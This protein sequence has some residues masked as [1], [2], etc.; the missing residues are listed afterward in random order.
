MNLDNRQAI[1]DN[2]HADPDTIRDA[3]TEAL[4]RIDGG[5]LGWTDTA[6]EQEVI[7]TAAMNPSTPADILE[8]LAQEMFT[9]WRV[10]ANEETEAGLLHRIVTDYSTFS[11]DDLRA[12]VCV[13]MH[14][15]TQPDTLVA[16][17]HYVIGNPRQG[18]AYLASHL[19]PTAQ[20]SERDGPIQT[21]VAVLGH[22]KTPDSL[23]EQIWRHL[24]SATRH[25]GG[26]T[27]FDPALVDD[28]GELL[29]GHYS[30]DESEAERIQRWLLLGEPTPK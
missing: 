18:D 21:L 13:A 22:Y 16:V 26:I 20:F 27:G 17:T 24:G 15:E 6:E 19:G 12:Q 4:E 28:L 14:P 5:R 29:D 30:L 23:R 9:Q 1:V 2:P 11:D 10:A 3:V 7:N 8:V 25:A